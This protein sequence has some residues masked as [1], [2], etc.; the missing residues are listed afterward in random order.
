[1]SD[2]E[3]ISWC[4]SRQNCVV[5]PLLTGT[6]DVNLCNVNEPSS[7]TLFGKITSKHA[8]LFYLIVLF[9]MYILTNDVTRVVSKYDP[10]EPSII[11][12]M[13]NFCNFLFLNFFLLILYNLGILNNIKC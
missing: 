2:D 6:Y 8:G 7:K 9:Y 11:I 3:G 1:M 4:H 12:S 13:G 10:R 5:Q